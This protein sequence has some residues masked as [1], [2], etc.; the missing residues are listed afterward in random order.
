MAEK[1][2]V[3]SQQQLDVLA[4]LLA[5]QRQVDA[6]ASVGVAPE[7]VSRWVNHDAVFIAAL[8]RCRK[9]IFD[10]SVDRLRALSGKAIDVLEE[11]VTA[12]E[13]EAAVLKA[14]LAILKAVGLDKGER[15]EG[16]IDAEAIEEERRK[17]SAW[18]S[19]FSM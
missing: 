16:L 18:D 14:S 19:L 11:I 8:N 12:P 4:L 17:A 2:K 15:P 7:T 6:A 3:L 13:S 5:G 1:K 9:D 10:A